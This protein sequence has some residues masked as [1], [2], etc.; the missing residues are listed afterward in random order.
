VVILEA[1]TWM[2]WDCKLHRSF[3]ASR[4]ELSTTIVLKRSYIFSEGQVKKGANP[5]AGTAR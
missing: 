2:G 4:Y 5:V 3:L 1:M